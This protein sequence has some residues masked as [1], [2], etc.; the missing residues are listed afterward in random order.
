[1]L[2]PEDPP[3]RWFLEILQNAGISGLS[4]MLAPQDAPNFW[5]LR[6]LLNAGT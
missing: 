2:A 3:K 1:M 4:E 5:Y 6:S